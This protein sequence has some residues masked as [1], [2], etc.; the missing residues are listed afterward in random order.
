M[1]DWLWT[2]PHC[3]R[4]IAD[5]HID[6]CFCQDLDLDLYETSECDCPGN[7]YFDIE[8]DAETDADE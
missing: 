4:L 7:P 8:S 5:T 2:R 3:Q 1:P 6:W